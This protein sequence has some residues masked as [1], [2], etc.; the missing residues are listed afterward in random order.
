MALD[1]DINIDRIPLPPYTDLQAALAAF[2][3]L[4]DVVSSS[5]PVAIDDAA[6]RGITIDPSLLEFSDDPDDRSGG[7]L[8]TRNQ[9]RRAFARALLERLL[10][11]DDIVL[12][13]VPAGTGSPALAGGLPWR[14]EAD[15]RAG[16]ELEGMLRRLNGEMRERGLLYEVL[17]WS[18]DAGVITRLELRPIPATPAGR[19]I[20]DAPQA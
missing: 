1:P 2:D 15:S 20:V 6:H 8:V 14:I 7:K 17:S 10:G 4:V 5:V 19:K 9:A 16:R 13:P 3:E 18:T 11:D 12:Y